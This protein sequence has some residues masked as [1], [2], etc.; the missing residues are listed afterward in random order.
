MTGYVLASL[1]FV[2]GIITAVTGELI[3]EEIRGWL[4]SLPRVILRLGARRLDPTG[5]ITIYDD[6]WLPELTCILRGA[7][8]RPIS[9]V[10]IG[11]K[12]SVGLL[13]TAK[14]IARHL[15]RIAPEP[16]R[17]G[18]SP[19][20]TAPAAQLALTAQLTS[21][22][23]SLKAVSAKHAQLLAQ[24]RQSEQALDCAEQAAACREAEASDPKITWMSQQAVRS[25][26]MALATLCQEVIGTERELITL[27]EMRART[28]RA[29]Q[30]LTSP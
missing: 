5:K 6:E 4:D 25:C 17:P 19:L 8:A 26:R 13:I 21:L 12:F 10:I 24:E 18:A 22:T 27:T 2:G 11:V 14:R 7:E 30:R 23:D 9:R 16:A 20:A 29:W 28:Q 15:H 3:S 1:I